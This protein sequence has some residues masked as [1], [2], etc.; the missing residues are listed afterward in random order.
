M[1][2]TLWKFFSIVVSDKQVS[3]RLKRKRFHVKE[4]EI[5]D[6]FSTLLKRRKNQFR[7]LT[8]DFVDIASSEHHATEYYYPLVE[9]FDKA[10]EAKE[11]LE[12]LSYALE[13]VED[14]GKALSLSLS[15]AIA[16]RIFRIRIVSFCMECTLK[17]GFEPYSKAVKYPMEPSLESKC[18]KCGGKTIFHVVEIE[19]PY[20]FGPLFKENRLPEFVIGYALATSIKDI[21]RLY[22][23]RKFR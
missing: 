9:A 14:L 10:G 11:N 2:R 20:T 8:K 6:L 13:K 16:Q 22:I 12:V 5:G 18:R 15:R 19:A 3:E 23:T 4:A 17:K 7:N 21:R 1:S